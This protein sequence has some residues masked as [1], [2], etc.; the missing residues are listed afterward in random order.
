MMCI[1]GF[2]MFFL[3]WIFAVACGIKLE[4][5]CANALGN[6]GISL[7]LQIAGVYLFFRG[8]TI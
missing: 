4:D 8:L 2:V 3:G 7:F 6:G 5:H 1:V